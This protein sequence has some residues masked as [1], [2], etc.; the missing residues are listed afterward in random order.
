MNCRRRMQQH[1][2]P[3][4]PRSTCKCFVVGEG[5][6]WREGP[7]PWAGLECR[8]FPW[9]SLFVRVGMAVSIENGDSKQASSAFGCDNAR[10]RSWL[11][12]RRPIPRFAALL[13]CC[14][15]SEQHKRRN[16]WFMRVI[17]QVSRCCCECQACVVGGL[18]MFMALR[19]RKAGG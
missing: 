5:R 4:S 15:G 18:S 10:H 3:G 12:S 7:W 19:W 1:R 6:R 17:Q 2:R 16:N 11:H 14:I 8:C 13:F 9:R